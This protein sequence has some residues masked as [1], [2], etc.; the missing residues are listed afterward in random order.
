VNDGASLCRVLADLDRTPDDL[1]RIYA[2]LTGV[3]EEWPDE[4]RSALAIICDYLEDRIAS[5]SLSDDEFRRGED[6][7]LLRVRI[8]A[9]RQL[10]R[11]RRVTCSDQQGDA[12]AAPL[13]TDAPVPAVAVE[14]ADEAGQSLALDVRPEAVALRGG[15]V[16]T[17][18]SVTPTSTVNVS[19]LWRACWERRDAT[20]LWPV[21]LSEGMR[22]DLLAYGAT[23]EAQLIDTAATIDVPSRLATRAEHKLGVEN[24]EDYEFVSETSRPVADI[25]T[26]DIANTAETPMLHLIPRRT[27]WEVA[28]ILVLR[29]AGWWSPHEHVAILRYFELRYGARLAVSNGATI[30]LALDAP[31]G[32]RPDGRTTAVERIGYADS[33]FG[34]REVRPAEVLA[35]TRQ[36]SIWGFWWD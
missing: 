33:T 23:A 24:V 14:L 10:L 36:D 30:T 7:D 3:R 25:D 18:M 1:P 22:P 31:L 4:I 26:V 35:V 12:R 29:D 16:V 15:V 20:G 8:E 2:L 28:A 27:G 19:R 21:V 6:E 34:V 17:S 9:N 11:W 5:P 13:S 32:D